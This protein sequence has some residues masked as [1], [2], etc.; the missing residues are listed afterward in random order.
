MPARLFP[1]EQSDLSLILLALVNAVSVA[2]KK[3]EKAI[4]TKSE[5]N[6]GIDPSGI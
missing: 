4:K 6:K 5:T 3:A 2:E 1:L